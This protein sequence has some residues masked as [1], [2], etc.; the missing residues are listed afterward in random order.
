LAG[1]N[2]ERVP[3]LLPVPLELQFGEAGFL[4]LAAAT[5]RSTDQPAFPGGDD[6]VIAWLP[7]HV[8]TVLPDLME[9]LGLA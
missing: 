1:R 9:P 4:V 3:A 8:R 2:D 5:C 6:V 7:A